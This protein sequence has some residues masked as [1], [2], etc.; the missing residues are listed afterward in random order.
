[1]RYRI[2]MP[3]PLPCSSRCV[4]VAFLQW[5]NCRIFA[6][7]QLSHFCNGSTRFDLLAVGGCR[8]A[9]GGE[10]HAGS[11]ADSAHSSVTITITSTIAINITITITITI[12][13]SPSHHHL[14]SHPHIL[15]AHRLLPLIRR[16][17]HR[18]P[19]RWLQLA[20]GAAAA[21][22]AADA[23]NRLHRCLP[24]PATWPTLASYAPPPLPPPF[25]L[26]RTR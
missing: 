18:P 2:Y 13:I 17:R 5:F 16:H 1:M 3:P 26:R 14:H 24:S 21:A 25:Q 22:A 15:R 6:M 9:G 11:V 8:G 23:S 10:A 20:A 12:T 19:A 7:V 4:I